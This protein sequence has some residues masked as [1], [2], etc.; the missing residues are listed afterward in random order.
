MG[1]FS[2]T[3]GN[4]ARQKKKNEKSVG[5]VSPRGLILFLLCK[6]LGNR[7]KTSVDNKVS[8][9]FASSERKP[10][11]SSL[12]AEGKLRDVLFWD[13]DVLV[14]FAYNLNDVL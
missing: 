9:K 13:V 12:P 11:R 3:L 14:M 7:P 6:L 4:R 8:A 2:K 10:S 5:I 1:N